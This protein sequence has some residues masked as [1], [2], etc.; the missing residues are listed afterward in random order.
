MRHFPDW[1][2]AYQQYTL[3]SEAPGVF[4]FWSGVSAIAGALERKVWIE[5]F[6]FQWTPNFYILLLAPPGIAS[7]TVTSGIGANLLR[8]VEGIRFGPNIITW[9]SLVT[10]LAAA[11]KLIPLGDWQNED[12]VDVRYITMSP[13][14]FISG[15]FGNLVD[16]KDRQM[17]DILVTLW[18][19]QIG[20]FNKSTKTQWDDCV[21]TPCVNLIACTTPSWLQENAPEYFQMGG[22]S[23]RFIYVWADRKRKLVAYPGY[24]LPDQKEYEELERKLVED[25]AA[26]SNL[27]GVYELTPEAIVW[28]S[29]WYTK[30]WESVQNNKVPDGHDA[31][32]Q[33]H[34]HK[35]AMVLAASRRDELVIEEKDLRDALAIVEANEAAVDRVHQLIGTTVESRGQLELIEILSHVKRISKP[36]LFGKLKHRMG[37]RQFDESLMAAI[38]LGRASLMQ[39][40]SE[41]VVKYRAP[42]AVEIVKEE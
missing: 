29:A 22:L 20:P 14:T 12:P 28:G 19:S 16:L 13:L 4:H 35:L 38:A 37:V 24:S 10:S 7:K 36:E 31:R 30:H 33:T 26:I 23:S 41:I 2:R 39:E 8:Q 11:K 17:V 40:G 27:K 34:I 42:Q 3:Y 9:Q 32:K 1:L 18:D 15:E 6:Y 21:E 25:L 5:Q